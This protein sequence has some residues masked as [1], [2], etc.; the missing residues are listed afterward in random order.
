MKHPRK[1]LFLV[2]ILG[3]IIAAY[4]IGYHAGLN[5][6]GPD[7]RA[8]MIVRR[9]PGNSMG[10][11]AI[12]FDLHKPEDVARLQVEEQRLKASGTEYYV[13]KGMMESTLSPEPDPR[14]V[15]SHR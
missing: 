11:S 1:T 8:L 15:N 10:T 6:Q 14:R 5:S 3:S 9:G 2:A 4:Y 7:H 12:W 13:A